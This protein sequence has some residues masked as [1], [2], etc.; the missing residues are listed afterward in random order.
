MIIECKWKE[1][2]FFFFFQNRRKLYIRIEDAFKRY[3]TIEVEKHQ[4]YLEK[5]YQ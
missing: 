3:M 4:A 1:N 2:V 5:T